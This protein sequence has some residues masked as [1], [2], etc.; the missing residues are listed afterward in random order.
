[1]SLVSKMRPCNWH[2]RDLDLKHSDGVTM[3][4]AW[5][6]EGF[7]AGAQRP[8]IWYYDHQTH[9]EKQR[10]NKNSEHRANL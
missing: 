9:E 2:Q 10:A 6:M 3:S 8:R 4:Q 1:V 5:S 7:G